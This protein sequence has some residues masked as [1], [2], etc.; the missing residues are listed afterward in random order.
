MRQQKQ[1]AHWLRTVFTKKATPQPAKNYLSC[2]F[3]LFRGRRQPL[4]GMSPCLLLLPSPTWAVWKTGQF[5]SVNSLPVS[6]LPRLPI[7]VFTNFFSPISNFNSSLQGSLGT[8]RSPRLQVPKSGIG[9]SLTPSRLKL[10]RHSTRIHH[11]QLGLPLR[12]RRP[13][14]LGALDIHV[15]RSYTS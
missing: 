8:S 5:E 11:H 2:C 6:L 9:A 4:L 3:S 10:P 1:P 15:P 13:L 7:L 14:Q 12:P